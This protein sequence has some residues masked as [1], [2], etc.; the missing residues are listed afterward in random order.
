MSLMQCTKCK[1]K[2]VEELAEELAEELV[3]EQGKRVLVL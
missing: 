2:P 3:E 1:K